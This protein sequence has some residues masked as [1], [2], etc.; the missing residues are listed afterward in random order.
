MM[1]GEPSHALVVVVC[2]LFGVVGTWLVTRG[3]GPK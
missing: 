3:V 2:M 1:P